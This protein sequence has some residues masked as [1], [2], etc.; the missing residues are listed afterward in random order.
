MLTLSIR[1]IPAFVP[2]DY[3]FTGKE[4]DSESGLDDF[5]AR[6]YGSSMGRFMT[7]DEPLEDQLAHDP[8]SW[9]LYS[10]VRN[11]P[12]RYTDPTGNACVQGSG[13]KYSD[14]NGG[15]ETCAQVDQNNKNAQAS[16]T[17]TAT[18]GSLPA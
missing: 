6:Y 17:V 14:D 1:C 8:Q 9:N 16:A 2:T 13:G 18:P 15:G 4:R 5:G 12:V 3:Q 10:Y 7:P 11:N